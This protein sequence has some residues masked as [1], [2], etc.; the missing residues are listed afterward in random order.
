MKSKKRKVRP[1]RLVLLDVRELKQL[2]PFRAELAH[3]LV[4]LGDQVNRLA[5][6]VTRLQMENE[7][8]S[9]RARKANATR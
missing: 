8:R 9:S 3:G 5:E 7:A 6:Q 2:E 4:Q 1:P